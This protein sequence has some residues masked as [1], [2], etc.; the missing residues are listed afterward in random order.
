MN[1]KSHL[2]PNDYDKNGDIIPSDWKEE[3][4]DLCKDM[5]GDNND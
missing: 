5:R 4:S 2:K 1:N 3:K